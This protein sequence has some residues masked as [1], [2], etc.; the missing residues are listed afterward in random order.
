MDFLPT[1]NT[2]YAGNYKVFSGLWPRALAVIIDVIILAP[3]VLFCYVIFSSSIS[4][5]QTLLRL[6]VDMAFVA[7]FVTAFLSHYLMLILKPMWQWIG[8]RG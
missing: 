2:N 7:L 6:S 8:W 5:K 1:E 4:L 3:V